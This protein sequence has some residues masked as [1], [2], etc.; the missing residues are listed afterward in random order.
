MRYKGEV[1]TIGFRSVLHVTKSQQ[2]VETVKAE[3]TSWLQDKKYPLEGGIRESVVERRDSTSTFAC[4]GN[5]EGQKKEWL[6]VLS[7]I[8][9]GKT[10]TVSVAVHDSGDPDEHVQVSVEVDVSP[11]EPETAIDLVETP[12]FVRRLLENL[13]VT[14]GAVPILPKVL[15]VR[16]FEQV[17]SLVDSIQNPER[18]ISIV[19]APSPDESLDVEWLSI[20]S[21]LTKRGVGNSSTYFLDAEITNSFN[22]LI[23]NDFGA[24]PGIIRTYA[25]GFDRTDV[26]NASLHRYLTPMKLAKSIYPTRGKWNVAKSLQ[27]AFNMASRLNY[28]QSEVPSDLSRSRDELS[29]IIERLLLQERLPE[30]SPAN[31]DSA[32]ATWAENPN[33]ADVT[34]STSNEGIKIPVSTWSRL[35]NFL[36]KFVD[37][38]VLSVESLSQLEG[39]IL[40]Q[41]NTITQIEELMYDA[42]A[43]R[44]SATREAEDLQK[45]INTYQADINSNAHR[46]RHLEDENKRLRRNSAGV[47]SKIDDFSADFQILRG[48]PLCSEIAESLNSEGPAEYAALRE[49]VVFTG[50]ARFTAELDVLTWNSTYCAKIVDYLEVLFDYV[51]AKKLPK[52]LPGGVDFYLK[53]SNLHAGRVTSPSNHSTESESTKNQ[54]GGLRV[55]PVPRNV[56][57][58]G[59][60]SMWNHFKIAEFDTTAP[61]LHYFDDTDNTGK[62]YIGYIGKHLKNSQTN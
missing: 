21:Q 47:D 55:F 24:G 53:N 35:S 16:T 51:Q 23:S 31:F 40:N 18:R 38:E 4:V 36:R 29:Q 59:S 26:S 43:K 11:A 46:I 15:E 48:L 13:A 49:H 5:L 28:M 25:P 50:D 58:S 1:V 45:K 9:Q 61:R 19:V 22:T 7:E 34:A 30:R 20:I 6:A 41:A 32:Y 60:V 17:Q 37:T 27:N 8:N 39:V 2:P 56:S 62:I 44:S 33:E 10:W 52:R 3:I 57:P 42:D 14:D 12:R 54:F